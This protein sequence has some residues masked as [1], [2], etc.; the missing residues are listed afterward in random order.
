MTTDFRALCVE[1]VNEAIHLGS[2]PYEQDPDPELIARARAALAEPEPV[3]A[4]PSDDEL[5]ELFVEI[6]QSGEPESWR[7]YARAV[8]ARWGRPS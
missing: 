1:L 5:D 4:G 8:L 2:L 7:S 3:P 6:D